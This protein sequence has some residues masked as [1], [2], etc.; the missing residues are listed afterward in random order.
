MLSLAPGKISMTRIESD[1]KSSAA[2]SNDDWDEAAGVSS[3]RIGFV[4]KVWL[5]WLAF[6]SGIAK[7]FDSIQRRFR[8]ILDD[9]VM[10]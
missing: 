1:V 9:D 6:L 8:Y 5:M 10:M 4:P 2:Y 7:Y 3:L